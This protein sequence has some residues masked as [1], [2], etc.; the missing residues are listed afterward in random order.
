MKGGVLSLTNQ[1][2][3]PITNIHTWTSAFM[4]YASIILEKWPS[5]G[6]ELLKYMHTVR[7]ANF[8]GFIGGWVKYDEQYRLRKSRG[9]IFLLG[10][11]RYG[12]MVDVRFNPGFKHNAIHL[13]FQSNK[14]SN[15]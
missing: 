1:R 12:V 8:R 10:S 3:P 4:I 6:N 15:E 9:P 7:L 13:K 2:K 14:P 5:K 11:C